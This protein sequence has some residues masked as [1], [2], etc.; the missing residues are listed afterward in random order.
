MAISNHERVGKA[1]E[2]LNQGLMPFFQRELHARYGDNWEAEIRSGMADRLFDNRRQSEL[3]HWD[4]QRLLGVM[5]DKWSDVFGRTLGHAERSLVSELR[6]VRNRWAHQKSFSLDDTYR[7]L[8]SIQRFLAAVSAPEADEIEK[9]KQQVLRQRF[10]EQAKRETKRASETPVEGKPM[11]GLKPW[12]E[13]ITPHPDV[14]SGR[15]QQA[16]FAADLRQVHRGEGADEYRDPQEFFRRTYLTEG[17]RLLLTGALERLSGKGGDPVVEL[18]TNFGG[19]KTHSMIALFHLFS[20]GNNAASLTGIDQVMQAAGVENVPEVNRAVLVAQALSP[21]IARKKKDGTEVRT[22]WGELAYQLGGRE[23][24]LMVADADKHG[25]SP[26]SDVLRE[27]FIKYGPCLVLI[28]E[29]VLFIRQLYGKDQENMP[30]GSFDANLSFAQSL[31]EA[32]RA[33][34]NTLVV[35][36]IPASEIEVGGEGG[37]AAL[38]RLKNTFGRL[39]SAW[40]PA[41]AEEGFEIVRRR[42]FQS[43][44]DP[45]KFAER[46][47]VVRSFADL[48]GQQQGEFPSECREAEY[49]RRMKAAYPIH[50]ELFDRLYNDW[51]SLDKFQRTRGV[52]RLMAAV[53][54]NLWERQ[55]GNL[56]IMPASVPVDAQS[57]QAELT[58]YMDDP[59][60]PV[61]EKDVDGPNSLP[62]ALD[63]NNP[64]LGRYSACRRVARTLYLGSAPTFNTSHRGLEDNRIKLGCVQPGETVATFGDALRRLT[65]QATHLYVDNT[66]YWFSTQPSV[67]RLAQDRAGQLSADVVMEKI[68][69]RLRSD[70]GSRGDFSRVHVC[71]TSGA[72]VPDERE[73]RLVVL[74]P[75]SA[76]TARATDSAARKQAQEILDHRGQSP[77]L[78]RNTLV[79]LAPDRTRLGELEQAVR[80]F[81]AWNSIKSESE[82]LNLDRFQTNQVQ[83]KCK[84][85]DETIK[86]RIPETYQWL[87]VPTQPDPQGTLEWE[88]TR[89]Q[90]DEPLA[91][92]AS[93]KL[94]SQGL[95]ASQ[96]AP[97]LLR[98]ELDRVPLWRGDRVG[99]KQLCD[100]FA[101]YLY[102][103]R[104]KDQNVILTS[105]RDGLSILTWEQETFAYAEGWDE[106]RGRYRGLRAGNYLGAIAADGSSLVVKP[107]VAINQL[108]EQEAPPVPPGGGET[109]APGGETGVRQP[110][111]G[112]TIQS[113]FGTPPQPTAA[114]LGR[115]HGVAELDATRLGRDAGTIAEAVVQHLAGLVG[116]NVEI[117]LEIHAE[118]PEGAPDSTVRTV[119]ENCRTLRFKSFGFEES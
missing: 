38:E 15:Y 89:L 69:E 2:L 102:L 19:G 100:D 118:L 96:F 50:P 55:D 64:N 114:K 104:L 60:V 35:A 31:T 33:T 61:I 53:I 56:M 44:S 97:T 63:R 45:A 65:D 84:E 26:G 66:R 117:T 10:E 11:G 83:S 72:D 25:V 21:G 4:T 58:R 113:G 71:P 41:S 110:P 99:V 27:L 17:L 68:R 73:A 98:I 95:M 34:P 7:A 47:A 62:L 22:M 42:L 111:R 85:A 39:E 107:E 74:D 115:F 90:G 8:D 13:V 32:A 93:K 67:T 94:I 43:I 49:E 79:F 91:I 16:E 12:R 1:L 81:I 116:A 36:S 51:G 48:Y 92:R 5:W 88:E 108:R 54:H 18:Q 86:R 80:Q 103:P 119:T 9:Q 57:V 75:E 70:P 82:D 30:A 29:W 105:I 106:Q 112:G 87:L 24:F 37:K 23:G 76:H 52:L 40:R 46:D 28:D 109:A 78:Y 3:I 6:E 14:A 77:R 101:Q 59:W 20:G